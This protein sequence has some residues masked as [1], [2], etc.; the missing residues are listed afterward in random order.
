[1]RAMDTG[2]VPMAAT[3]DELR[4]W[5]RLG[6]GADDALLAG[7]IR[8]ATEACEAFTGMALVAREMTQILPVRGTWQ[9]LAA[10]PV[11]AITGVDGVPAEGS[12]FALPITSYAIDIDPAGD[13][14]VRVIEPGSAGRIRVQLRAGM[15]ASAGAVP[16][17]LRQGIILLA[18]QIYRA[19]DGGEDGGNGG[20]GALALPDAIAACWRGSRRVRLNAAAGPLS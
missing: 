10:S 12:L 14:W 18:A 8:A 17:A 19:R 5:L 13:G 11:I 3:I 16:D 4:A 9:R 6:A 7:P 2:P 15:A 1:M 20:A